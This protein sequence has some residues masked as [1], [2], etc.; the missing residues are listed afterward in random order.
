MLS[1][2]ESERLRR[3]AV[4]RLQESLH[5]SWSYTKG[6][7][8]NSVLKSFPRVL[9][10]DICLHLNRNLLSSCPA[11]KTASPGVRYSVHSSVCTVFERDWAP[12]RMSACAGH[13]VQQRARAA[14]RLASA[15]GR[16]DR[17]A[18]LRGARQRRGDDRRR[19]RRGARCVSLSVCRAVHIRPRRSVRVLVRVRAAGKGDAFGDSVCESIAR[20][21][22]AQS[23][24]Q[25]KALSYCDLNK[26]TV[27]EIAEIIAI[28]PDF[29]DSVLREFNLTFQLQ[30]VHS[31]TPTPSTVP[32]PYVPF[33]SI[34]FLHMRAQGEYLPSKI[35]NADEETIRFIRAR[36]PLLQYSD[37]KKRKSIRHARSIISSPSGSL[38][39]RLT[40][41]G[42]FSFYKLLMSTPS[43][44]DQLPLP[45]I[46]VLSIT[47]LHPVLIS[48]TNK[49]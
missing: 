32:L 2:D 10:A 38:S 26:I 1:I 34:P 27:R 17:V 3:C 11:F 41:S 49:S 9:Q 15:R 35:R 4:C 33:R 29:G 46:T 18:V 44:N 13:E 14:G 22:A 5:N 23:L 42:N 7:D 48:S 19:V 40:K 30:S 37:L 12:R 31:C 45:L 6:V 16:P 28:Y 21:I 8:M 20:P 47:W 25:V 36:H 24:Y 39:L 43:T